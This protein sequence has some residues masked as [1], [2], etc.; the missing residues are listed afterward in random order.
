MPIWEFLITFV[1]SILSAMG[2]IALIASYMH[3]KMEKW[4]F[5]AKELAKWRRELESNPNTT[6]EEWE[7]FYKAQEKY[8]FGR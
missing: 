4:S 2:L 5:Q 1:L 7:E 6:E 3:W 8:I